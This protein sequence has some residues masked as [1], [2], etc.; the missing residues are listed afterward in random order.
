MTITKQIR[1]FIQTLPADKT[2]T[3]AKLRHLGSA[4][5]IR[6]TLGRLATAGVIHRVGRGIYAKPKKTK[7][8]T[9]LPSIE[10]TIQ[11]ISETTGEIIGTH[12]AEAARQLQLTTQMPLNIILYTTGKSRQ[13]V[14]CNN[15]VT[16]Q[17]VSPKKIVCPGTITEI[18]ISALWYLGQQQVTA[19][20]IRKIANII[21]ATELQT[22]QSHIAQMPAW[23]ANAFY[24]FNKE[25]Q[26]IG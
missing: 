3:G 8:G 26:P 6:K 19:E 11:S 21:P 1:Q 5:T 4:D 9:R 2:F 15:T 14:V 10:N 13:L 16:L 20:T 25:N 7:Y 17:H 23:M 24:Q 22:V 12:G 18:V